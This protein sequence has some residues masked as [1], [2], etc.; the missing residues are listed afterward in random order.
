MRGHPGGYEIPL[1]VAAMINYLVFVY[2]MLWGIIS[3]SL[4]L[5]KIR[6]CT[7]Y[8]SSNIGFPLYRAQDEKRACES[9]LTDVLRVLA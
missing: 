7:E 1:L 9:L 8:R 4:G 6:L 2:F 5:S 3:L